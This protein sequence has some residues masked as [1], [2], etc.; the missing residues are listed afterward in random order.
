ML[1]KHDVM[2]SLGNNPAVLIKAIKRAK[3]TKQLKQ[4]RKSVTRLL[5][6]YLEKNIPMSITL[7]IISELNDACVKH[8]REKS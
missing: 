6:G 3:K 1:S 4:I 8:R 7:K 2:V 5:R